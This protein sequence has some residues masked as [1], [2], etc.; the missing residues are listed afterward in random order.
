[1]RSICAR[2]AQELGVNRRLDSP[3]Y[4]F[5]ARRLC[6]ALCDARPLAMFVV[7]PSGELLFGNAALGSL[8]GIPAAGLRGKLSST[9]LGRWCLRIERDVRMVLAPPPGAATP[10]VV[11]NP[12][13]EKGGGWLDLYRRDGEVV[14][15][16]GVVG[17]RGR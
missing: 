7:S 13:G 10:L 14:G 12:Q 15:V 6:E 17:D 2:S 11:H 3:D 9:L 4:G 8:L 5:A 16:C 1:M